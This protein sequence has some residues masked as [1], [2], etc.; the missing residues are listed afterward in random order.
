MSAANQSEPMQP[1]GKP[2][3]SLRPQILAPIHPCHAVPF[4]E[5]RT[6]LGDRAVVM[7]VTETDRQSCGKIL[8]LKMNFNFIFN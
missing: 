4:A 1:G 5:C 6:V 7:N 8:K 3:K 2:G